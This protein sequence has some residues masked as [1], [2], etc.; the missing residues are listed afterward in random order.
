MLNAQE[1]DQE[2]SDILKRQPYTV[3]LNG[4]KVQVDKSVF[5]LDIGY[6]SQ[7]LAETLK[8]Y[9]PRKALDMGCGTG[10]L[11]ML[12]KRN[13]A[14]EVWA[15]DRHRPSWACTMLNAFSNHLTLHFQQSD[16]FREV[17][18][19]KFDL[20]VFDQPY[21][22][23]SRDLFGGP[24]PDGGK[25]VIERF[26]REVPPYLPSNGVIIMPFSDMAGKKHD[27]KKIA[28]DFKVTT[29]METENEF[30]RHFVYQISLA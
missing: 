18:L 26:L 17:P 29:V 11:A 28:I 22:P 19:Q 9:H 20:I 16:L 24:C 13:G 23:S 30:G 4:L 5:P 21:Y 1:R 27:P 25:K 6:T 2:L 14:S 3:D 7:Y 12:L 8:R 10:Y 15:V